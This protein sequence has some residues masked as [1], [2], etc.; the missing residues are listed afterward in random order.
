MLVLYTDGLVERRQETL[1]AGLERL[2]RAVV[3]GPAE[4][5]QLCQHVLSCL[6]PAK[7]LDDDVTALMAKLTSGG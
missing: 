5:V 7:R 2:A 3:S 4:P 1:D 6:L